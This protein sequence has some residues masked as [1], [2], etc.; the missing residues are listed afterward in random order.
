MKSISVSNVQR[1]LKV[2][3]VNTEKHISNTHTI[4][5]FLENTHNF[6][7]RDPKLTLWRGQKFYVLQ[8]F[9]NLFM[10]IHIL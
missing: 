7:R 10:L 3:C 4:G 9:P 8:A 1:N 6:K 2:C 5:G